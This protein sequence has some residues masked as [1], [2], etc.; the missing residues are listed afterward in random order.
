MSLYQIAKREKGLTPSGKISVSWARQKATGRIGAGT[1]AEIARFLR[2]PNAKDFCPERLGSRGGYAKAGYLLP[3]AG[4]AEK[5]CGIALAR[6]H[7]GAPARKKNPRGGTVGDA[8]ELYRKFRE[9]EPQFIDKIAMKLPTAAMVI[10]YC[11]G[12]LYNTTRNGKKEYYKHEF[13]GKSCPLLC[14][15]ADGK[16]LFFVGGAYDFTEDGIVDRG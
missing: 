12:V 3:R 9:E 5:D 6:K 15:S 13:T 2:N 10:G 8:I 4:R 16:Q 14:A 1:R 11:D 7:W